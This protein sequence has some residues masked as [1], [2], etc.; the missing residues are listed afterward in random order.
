MLP[1]AIEALDRRVEPHGQRVVPARRGSR[2]ATHRRGVARAARGRPRRAPERGRPHRRAAPRPTTSRSRALFWS[3]TTQDPRGAGSS[4]PPSSTTPCS[5]P[6]SG[7]PSTPAPRSC[8]CPSTARVGSTSTRW[9]PS[10]TRHGDDVALISVM[11]ANNEVGTLQPLPR[12]RLRSRAA[13]GDPRARRRRPGRRARSPVDFAA[14]GLDAMTVSGHKI[15]GPARRRRP[16]SRGATWHLTPGAARR[17]PGARR[18]VRHARHPGRAVVRGR[19]RRRRRATV[20]RPRPGCPRCATTS[21]ARVRDAVPDA[22]LRGPDRRRP[23]SAPAPTTRSRPAPGNAHFTFPGC[24][25]DSLL[26][27]LDSAGV[28]CSTGSAC[29]AGVPQPSPRPARDG[30]RASTTPG[31]R[32]GSASATRPPPPTST[33]CSPPCRTSSPARRPPASPRPASQGG[34]RPMRVLAALSGRRRLRGR[35]GAR[36][37]RGPRRRRR[38]HGAVAEPRPVPHRVAR[39]LLDRGRRATR[40]ARP[41]SWASRTTCGTC[42]SGSRTPSSPTSSPS[43]RPGAPRTRACAATSTSSSRRCST[44]PSPSGSTPSAPGTTPG[45]CCARTRVGEAGG[46]AGPGVVRELH[47]AADLA[48]DQSYVLAV[49]GPDRLA[50]AMFPLGEVDLQGRGA[51][52]GGG[53]RPERLGQAGLLRH[54]LRGRRRHPRLP[55]RP[56]GLPAGRR[57]RHRRPGGRRAR[58]RLR[59]HRRPAQGTVDRPSCA[60]RQAALRARRSAR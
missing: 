51:R 3:R 36:G 9:L 31:A 17:R 14:S 10:S 2:R 40:G 34:G 23:R 47:R 53:A 21:S 8:S 39:L 33:P 56:A 43:T 37:R 45:S 60:R 32:C 58:R 12:G 18:A 35:R 46:R 28:Q 15:G 20:R 41:T 57:R 16:R 54:L 55:A 1:R 6:P 49:M 30:R 7:W 59:V 48:K 38:A 22:V 52:R 24:E 13:H 50:R 4:S 42:P 27:L 5:T 25:G 26:Y 11:W 44:R 19:R 29:Q